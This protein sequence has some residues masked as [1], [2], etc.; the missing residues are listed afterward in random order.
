MLLVLRVTKPP[1][2]SV[3]SAV[4]RPRASARPSSLA[5]AVARPI[6]QR[7]EERNNRHSQRIVPSTR[8]RAH[9][10]TR[11][12]IR[13][14][15]VNLYS[16]RPLLGGTRSNFQNFECKHSGR[17]SPTFHVPDADDETSEGTPFLSWKRL[18]SRLSKHRG[19]TASRKKYLARSLVRST[20]AK[21]C[22]RLYR[23]LFLRTEYVFRRI[24][25]FPR[26]HLAIP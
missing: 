21:Y 18:I 24:A 22:R 19:A 14:Y 3:L 13:A 7:A 16:Y 8:L 10:K 5:T 1:S 9:N 2:T 17:R 12:R 26:Y 20:G 11:R 25:R 6:T 15:A 23:D 4:A